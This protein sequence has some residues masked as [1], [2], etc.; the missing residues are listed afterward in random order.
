MKIYCALIKKISDVLTDS[1]ND[2]D[3]DGEND[4]HQSSKHQEN[5]CVSSKL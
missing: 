1:W 4:N 3:E 2:K 5:R